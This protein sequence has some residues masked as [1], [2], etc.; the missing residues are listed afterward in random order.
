MSWAQEINAIRVYRN[1][2]ELKVVS[3]AHDDLTHVR[4]DTPI[5]EF[6]DPWAEPLYHLANE[7]ALSYL[8]RAVVPH[9]GNRDVS[10][11]AELLFPRHNTLEGEPWQLDVWC[12]R[13]FTQP[14]AAP[15]PDFDSA[16]VGGR[17]ASFLSR[18][19][20]AAAP[21][22]VVFEDECIA[23][24]T[25]VVAYVLAEV[26]ERANRCFGETGE[27]AKTMPG[28]VRLAVYNDAQ[29]RERLQFCRVF[30]EGRVELGSPE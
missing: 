29:L 22:S 21:V 28:D 12:H 13:H 1:A 14:D 10:A 3:R 8:Q 9:M 24:I 26:L 20:D 15:I 23:G 30:W 7:M 4:L 11:A 25:R 27:H 17:I 18:F 16:Y 5:A 19:G 2:E 6:I